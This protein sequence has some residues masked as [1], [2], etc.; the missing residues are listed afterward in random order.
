MAQTQGPVDP[1][2][3]FRAK[4]Y[5]G[6]G[7]LSGL[8]TFLQAINLI[9]AGQAA[10]IASI[11][12]G[13][14]TLLS[15]FGFG[16]AAAKTN[17]QV[18]DGTFDAAPEPVVEPANPAITAVQAIQAV[19][20]QFNDLVTGVT[21]G[22]QQVQDVA[23]GLAAALPALGGIAPGSLAQQVLAAVNDRD[24]ASQAVNSR[25]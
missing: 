6:L 13:V 8:V 11:I 23:G 24:A 2:A 16:L 15:T 3:G 10:S 22:V 25:T 17:A 5:A 19:G 12:G 18:K 1:N 14:T 21:A 4:L 7:L 9:D 20:Q